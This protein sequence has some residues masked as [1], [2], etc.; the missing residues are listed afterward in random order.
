MNLFTL[1]RRLKESMH[2][3]NSDRVGDEATLCLSPS[4]SDML[5]DIGNTCIFKP[6]LSSD[7]EQTYLS[8]TFQNN[9]ALIG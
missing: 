8:D 2:L 5:M 3:L 6:L 4:L 9:I 1:M 7:M